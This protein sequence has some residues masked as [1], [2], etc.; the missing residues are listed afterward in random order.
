MLSVKTPDGTWHLRLEQKAAWPSLATN[1]LVGCARSP[2]DGLPTAGA[3][4][5]GE[6]RCPRCFGRKINRSVRGGS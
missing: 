6:P 1:Y 4:P 5:G 3:P 2:A